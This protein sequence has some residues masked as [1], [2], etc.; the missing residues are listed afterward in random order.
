MSHIVVLILD[1]KKLKTALWKDTVKKSKDKPQNEKNIQY[2]YVYQ[3]TDTQE[4]AR[5]YYN[6]I[7]R[8]AT[9][10]ENGQKI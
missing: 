1:L 5:N 10:Q 2:I 3:I 8:E 6:S 9:K 4:Q 7:I